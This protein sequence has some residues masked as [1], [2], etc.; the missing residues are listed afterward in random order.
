MSFT[1]RDIAVM[2]QIS[3][4]IFWS[5]GSDEHALWLGLSQIMNWNWEAMWNWWGG[6]SHLYRLHWTDPSW[7]CSVLGE[8]RSP[9]SRVLGISC[10]SKHYRFRD[11]SSSCA[12]AWDQKCCSRAQGRTMQRKTYFPY[13]S[14]FSCSSSLMESYYLE[15][16]LVP[17]TVIHSAHF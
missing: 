17:N 11:K 3:V 9:N 6:A 14:T 7:K 12:S 5:G 1:C 16:Q 10:C 15:D 8:E 4:W 13:S 2:K